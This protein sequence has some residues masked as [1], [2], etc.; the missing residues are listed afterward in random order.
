MPPT[1]WVL[2][3]VMFIWIIICFIVTEITLTQSGQLIFF[4]PN[5]VKF[6]DSS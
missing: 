3:S 5:Q 2:N 4:Y 6:L 1:S